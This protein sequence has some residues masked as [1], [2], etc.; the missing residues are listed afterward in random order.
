MLTSGLSKLFKQRFVYLKWLA[1]YKDIQVQKGFEIQYKE[2]QVEME[3]P[4]HN[5]K[6]RKLH[7]FPYI[8]SMPRISGHH[9]MLHKM[10]GVQKCHP[11][12]LSSFNLAFLLY[13]FWGRGGGRKD[14]VFC[15]VHTSG[16]LV[17]VKLA[18]DIS[19]LLLKWLSDYIGSA[20]T[21]LSWKH[22]FFLFWWGEIIKLISRNPSS[23]INCHNIIQIFYSS[24]R[25]TLQY[26]SQNHT[27]IPHNVYIS[28]YKNLL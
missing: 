7:H 21:W 25:H 15:K 26:F 12:H 6:E 3:S 9:N 5:Q 19:S 13:L 20:N 22:T 16:I 2:A 1:T 18:G 23:I 8:L 11:S 17:A 14:V 24:P 28:L 10:D 4:K 27:H